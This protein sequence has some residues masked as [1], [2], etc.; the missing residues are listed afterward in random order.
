M[1]YT[2]SA[3]NDLLRVRACGRETPQMPPQACSAIAG[4]VQRSGLTRILVEL[5]QKIALS[6]TSQFQIVDRMPALGI[7][8]FHRI[9]LVHYTPGL[10]EAS[11]LLEV[12]AGNRGLNLKNF[13][14]LDAAL[15]WLG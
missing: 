4:E 9:A 12:A 11:D 13:R 5:T 10:Y 3:E 15:A 7:T 8:P 1:E 14:A 6:S 2:M